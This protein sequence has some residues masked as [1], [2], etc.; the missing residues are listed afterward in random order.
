MRRYLMAIVCPG[1]CLAAKRSRF[2]GTAF[3]AWNLDGK[4]TKT[5]D[6]DVSC[7]CT[8]VTFVKYMQTY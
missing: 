6:L 7:V 4:R 5:D 2:Y 1:C 3:G 8:L